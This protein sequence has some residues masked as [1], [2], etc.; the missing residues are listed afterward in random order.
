MIRKYKESFSFAFKDISG[1]FL[2]RIE[3]DACFICKDGKKIHKMINKAITSK[4]R[5]NETVTIHVTVPSLLKDELVARFN[6]TL[7]IKMIST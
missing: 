7:S 2:K 5:Q 6:L 3:D 4:K 1:E